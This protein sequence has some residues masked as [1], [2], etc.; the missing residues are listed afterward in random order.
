[1]ADPL[2]FPDSF[3]DA[4]ISIQV[5]HHAR[6]M[7]IEKIVKEVARVLKKGGFVFITVPEEKSQ[8]KKFVEIEPCTFIPLDGPEKGLPHYY[9]TPENFDEFFVGFS[10][11]D[12]H[13][14]STGHYCVSGFKR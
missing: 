14:D 3:F 13:V 6:P 9:F 4:V 2:P 5:I 11:T 8:A 10:F 1:M 12:I 7:T